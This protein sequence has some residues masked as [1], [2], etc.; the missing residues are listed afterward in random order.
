MPDTAPCPVDGFVE[1][2]RG[3]DNQGSW[4]C[5]V[6]ATRPGQVKLRPL[7]HSWRDGITKQRAVWIARSRIVLI[8]TDEQADAFGLTGAS[9]A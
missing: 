9:S 3:N 2:R 1:Y 4:Y 5:R 8:L 6:L 7:R